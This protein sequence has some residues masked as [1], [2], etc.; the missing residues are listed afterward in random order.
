VEQAELIQMNIKA[1]VDLRGF[2]TSTGAEHRSGATEHR[3]RNV[4][5]DTLCTLSEM[6]I[7]SMHFE[8]PCMRK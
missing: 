8:S 3:S 1:H 2:S 6:L 4:Y 5:Q 7:T